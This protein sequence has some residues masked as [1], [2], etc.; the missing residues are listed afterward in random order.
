MAETTNRVVLT[1][2]EALFFSETAGLVCLKPAQ[3]SPLS[4][5][6]LRCDTGKLTG[7]RFL[8]EPKRRL[9]Q[10][11]PWAPERSLAAQPAIAGRA[12]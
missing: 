8:S 12:E 1:R 3:H 6:R 5:H 7:S 10:E 4:A 11:N 9:S 2:R